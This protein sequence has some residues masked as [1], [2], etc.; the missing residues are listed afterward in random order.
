MEGRKSLYRQ[1][2]NIPGYPVLVVAAVSIA[3]KEWIFQITR[4]I[5]R[6]VS[7]PLLNANAWHHRTDALSSVAVL[8]GAIAGSAGW[9][10]GDQSAAAVVGMMIGAVGV[11]FLWKVFVELTE[12]SISAE[13]R[14]SIVEAV[15][16][17]TGVRGWHRL[18]TRLVGREVF[19][20]VHVRVD[21][22][23]SVDE[24]HQICS[25]V[26]RAAGEAL[27]RPINVV[28]HCEPDKG[29]AASP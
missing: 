16:R 14:D 18:R 7:S 19:M 3:S 2:E 25:A 11:R 26:E 12:G 24:G 27:E 9:S 6:L 10:H 28:V 23:L 8:F 17:V 1:E 4:R 29:P 22:G 13:E 21:A 5:A 15:E 20:D